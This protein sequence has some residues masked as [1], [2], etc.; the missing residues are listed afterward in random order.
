MAL[1]EATGVAPVGQPGQ[2][3]HPHFVERQAGSS[4]VDGGTIGLTGARCVVRTLRTPFDLERINADLDEFLHVFDGAQ[5]LGIEDVGAVLVFLDNVV[6]T[7]TA[8]RLLD[9]VDVARGI[10]ATGLEGKSQRQAFVQL[11]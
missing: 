9:Q 2:G 10:I 7:G 1:K 5:I 8:F 4:G 11:P 3:I 6:G